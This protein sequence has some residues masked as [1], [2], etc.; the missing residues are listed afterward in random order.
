MSTTRRLAAVV[1]LLMA[2]LL[3]LPAGSSA[4]IPI[5]IPEPNP[6]GTPRPTPDPSPDPSDDPR[7]SPTPDPRPSPDGGGGRGGGKGKKE[8]RYRP[9]PAEQRGIARWLTRART[10]SS[11]TTR[12]LELLDRATPGPGAPDPVALR[13]GFGRFPVVG[14]TWYQDDYGAPR[15]RG[16]YVFHAG[17]DLFAADGTP[18]ISVVDGFIWRIGS[19]SRGGNAIW[20]QGDDGVRY[21]YGHLKGFRKGIALGTRVQ[22]GELLGWVGETGQ[23]NGYPHVHFEVN[24]GGLGTV[25]PKPILDAWLRDA[26]VAAVRQIATLNRQIALA[27]FGAA[28]W[29]ALFGMLGEPAAAPAPLWSAGWTGSPLL[30]HL[31]LVLAE[32]AASSEWTASGSYGERRTAWDDV[33]APITFEE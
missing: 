8:P 20:L 17:T 23:A 7:P 30:S 28:R 3:A 9:T 4:Q 32:L 6:T 15:Y 14:Y 31:D 27:P 5:P 19:F 21:Y 26:E 13:T 25:N 29:D 22:L 12:L 2:A 1:A 11:T 18:V 10:P 24:P 16:S 33:L